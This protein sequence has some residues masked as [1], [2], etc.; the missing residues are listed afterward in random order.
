MR[1]ASFTSAVALAVMT[2]ATVAIA[3]G[4]E[5]S[6]PIVDQPP[7]PTC[8]AS[9]AEPAKSAPGNAWDGPAA[10]RMR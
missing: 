9:T 1:V 7:T 6:P 4:E 3:Q 8:N 10:N 5:A 2:A